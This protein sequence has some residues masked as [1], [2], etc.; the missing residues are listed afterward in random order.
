MKLKKNDWENCSNAHKSHLSAVQTI[1]IMLCSLHKGLFILHAFTSYS[2]RFSF[3]FLSCFVFNQ[4]RFNLHSVWRDF[5]T[6]IVPGKD[7]K[8]LIASYG[9]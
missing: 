6:L 5:W 7:Q 2:L 4:V 3:C 8:I 9:I 1:S